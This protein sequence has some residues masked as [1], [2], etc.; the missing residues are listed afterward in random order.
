[1]E[2]KKKNE[3]R[4][5]SRREFLQA[6]VV[7]AAGGYASLLPASVLREP[8]GATR[9]VSCFE[10]GG[11]AFLRVNDA[12]R[13][14]ADAIFPLP[15]LPFGAVALSDSDKLLL[16]PHD[17]PEAA[18]FSFT[19][20]SIARWLPAHRNGIFRGQTAVSPDG[21]YLLT[22]EVHGALRTGALVVRDSRTLQV[23]NEIATGGASPYDAVF[24]ENG[25]RVLVTD[26]GRAAGAP[27]SVTAIAWPSGR[28]EETWTCPSTSESFLRILAP[29]SGTFVVT[30]GGRGR[31]DTN[32]NLYAC[33]SGK[34]PEAV[35]LPA[36]LQSCTSH[37]ALS[38][39]GSRAAVVMPWINRVVLVDPKSGAL[40]SSIEVNAPRNV[41][42]SE[43]RRAFLVTVLSGEV[44]EIPDRAYASLVPLIGRP[45]RRQTLA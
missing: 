6:S 30:A 2:R 38:G 35:S 25:T 41:T 1:M 45:V 22:T 19:A 7:A 39:S 42:Y 36:S 15:F 43:A 27:S 20:G 14:P 34:V 4:G 10:A 3:V 40:R 31:R 18:I 29:A 5:Q 32:G 11:N 12:S 13:T 24:S 23:V 44:Y 28:V 16:V 21:A 33:A 8:R 26:S 17:G 37:V 9:V